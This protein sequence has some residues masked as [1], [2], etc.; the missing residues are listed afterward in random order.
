MSLK[1]FSVGAWYAQ[2]LVRN[3]H[4]TCSV[5]SE[6]LHCSVQLP[7]EVTNS[8][9]MST[10]TDILSNKTTV[11]LEYAVCSCCA[12]LHISVRYNIISSYR[13]LKRFSWRLC[14]WAL[15][16]SKCEV[17]PRKNV[18]P[19]EQ[20][21]MGLGYNI[22]TEG[23]AFCV[24]FSC[25]KTSGNYKIKKRLFCRWWRISLYK[26]QTC[27]T[28]YSSKM[29]QRWEPVHNVDQTAT[30][31]DG[32]IPHNGKDVQ[33]SLKI[34]ECYTVTFTPGQGKQTGRRQYLTE[35]LNWCQ[36]F[37]TE[38]KSNVCRCQNITKR[39]CWSVSQPYGC[40]TCVTFYPYAP[41]MYDQ[42]RMVMM[43]NTSGLTPVLL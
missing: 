12:A 42:Q 2:N 29:Q 1:R 30:K 13:D 7:L 38:L 31:Q 33:E 22:N 3:L 32:I 8:P 27:I 19:N 17:N 6:T 41:L 28:R 15:I 23:E 39:G 34:S 20:T 16:A 18:H 14:K 43:T 4:V 24:Y 9:K 26:A 40:I 35:P 11:T 37:W 21:F 10:R 25:W 36:E 5:D